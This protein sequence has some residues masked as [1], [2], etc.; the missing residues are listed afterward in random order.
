MYMQTRHGDVSR[1]QQI[2][3]D[4]RNQKRHL[5]STEATPGD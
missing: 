5:S 1:Q 4:L 3:V 2:R